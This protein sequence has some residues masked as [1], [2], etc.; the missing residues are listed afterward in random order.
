MSRLD[1][2]RGRLLSPRFLRRADKENQ[3]EMLSVSSP[4][5]VCEEEKWV[6]A[7][8]SILRWS[9]WDVGVASCFM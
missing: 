7:D 2:S 1:K 9:N 3:M 8:K 4:L 5:S 6:K